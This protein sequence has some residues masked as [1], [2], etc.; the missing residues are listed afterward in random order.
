MNYIQL[1]RLEQITPAAIRG[2]KGLLGWDNQELADRAGLSRNTV[3]ATTSSK[4]ISGT[5]RTIRSIVTALEEA[6]II[7]VIDPETDTCGV[8]LRNNENSS[9][10]SATTPQGHTQSSPNG[11]VIP[12]YGRFG[13]FAK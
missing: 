11:T 10:R 7:F 8:L 3:Q 9:R 12:A 5:L 2:A 13:R 6:G 4:E 1:A